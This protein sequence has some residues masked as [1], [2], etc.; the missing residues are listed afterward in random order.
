MSVKLKE[1]KVGSTKRMNK[2]LLALSARSAYRG[3]PLHTAGYT[4]RDSKR[5]SQTASIGAGRTARISGSSNQRGA[6]ALV[7]GSITG[8][9]LRAFLHEK[10]K[11]GRTDPAVP[12]VA[13][14]DR[15]RVAQRPLRKA[16]SYFE[17]HGTAS[18]L[19]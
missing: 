10:H 18:N 19:G 17:Q 8:F 2:D 16:R 15:P 14:T 9:V 1:L 5:Q 12:S 11:Q 6:V 4:K 3:E 13:T 7:F